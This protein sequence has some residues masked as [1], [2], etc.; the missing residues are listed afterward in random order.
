VGEVLDG[1]WASTD[2]WA[3]IDEGMVVVA[4][5][6]PMA[7]EAMIAEADELKDRIASGA[8]H[9]FT[10]P[11]MAQDGSVLVPEGEV[12]SDEQLLGMS[13]FAAGVIGSIP[14]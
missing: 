5:Y 12:A 1:T 7:T 11:I 6:G 4:D 2:T 13:S 9:P 8:Y 14:G 10:G 3:G